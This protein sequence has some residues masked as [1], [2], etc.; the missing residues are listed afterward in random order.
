MKALEGRDEN[1]GEVTARIWRRDKSGKGEQRWKQNQEEKALRARGRNT[2]RPSPPAGGKGK[3][4]QISYHLA[5]C[6]TEVLLMSE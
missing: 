5:S 6:S 2:D 1:Y 4:P 3:K